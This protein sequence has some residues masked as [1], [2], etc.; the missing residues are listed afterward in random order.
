MMNIKYITDLEGDIEYFKK[1]VNGNVLAWNNEGKLDFTDDN[2]H[3]VFGGDVC[4]RGQDIGLLELLLDLKT[5]HPDRVHLI[6]GNRDANKVR[7]INEL[8]HNPNESLTNSPEDVDPTP[9]VRDRQKDSYQAYLN[10]QCDSPI[11]R[12]K[13]ILEKTMGAPNAFSL[14]K[15]E[16]QTKNPSKTIQDEDVYLSFV[17]SV[18][19]NGLMLRYLK[20]AEVATIIGDQLYVHG[21][22]TPQ[23]MGQVPVGTDGTTIMVDDAKAWVNGINNW[24][25]TQLEAIINSQEASH[26]YRKVSIIT[27]FIDYFSGPGSRFTGLTPAVGHMSYARSGTPQPI[28]QKVATWLIQSNIHMVLVGHNPHGG[29]PLVI[30]GTQSDADTKVVLVSAD[31]SYSNAK[32]YDPTIDPKIKEADPRGLAV[33]DCTVQYDSN[34]GSHIVVKGTDNQG[35]N[36]SYST[37]TDTDKFIG[38]CF[39]ENNVSYVVEIISLQ[40]GSLDYVVS[41]KGNNFDVHYQTRTKEELILLYNQG[42]FVGMT[43][44]NESSLVQLSFLSANNQRNSNPV[45]PVQRP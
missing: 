15:A 5:R 31:T 27:P 36:Y 26:T 6:I 41:T 37:A 3:L 33:A 9:Y 23:N 16:L 28:D 29:N 20:E 18:Q 13:W 45:T 21:S 44:K 7:F 10:G 12:L 8:P 30:K 34:T 22:V 4:D 2:S 14:R 25:N 39:K 40:N 17:E 38:R 19:T 42:C 35:N 24:K 1:L 32:M 11:L 43:P